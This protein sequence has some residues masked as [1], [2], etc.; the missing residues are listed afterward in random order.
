MYIKGACSSCVFR[1]HLVDKN[2]LVER[3]GE[4]VCVCVCVCVC[5]LLPGKRRTC[6]F[7]SSVLHST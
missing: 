6:L 7:I 2:V 1:V 4:S 5:V 3:Q